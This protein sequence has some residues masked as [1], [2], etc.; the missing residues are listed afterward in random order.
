MLLKEPLAT[1]A[2][3]E[4]LFRTITFPV[5]S[6]RLAQSTPTAAKDLEVAEVREFKKRLQEVIELRA[7]IAY[8]VNV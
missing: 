8:Q 1:P 5:S 7:N 6:P 4:K 3:G 2:S